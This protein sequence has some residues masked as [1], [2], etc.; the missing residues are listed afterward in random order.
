MR[1]FVDN[2]SAYM[3][4]NLPTHT[5]FMQ[6]YKVSACSRESASISGTVFAPVCECPGETRF[7]RNL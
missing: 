4:R 1:Y 3:Y 6:I 7:R 2:L 5:P